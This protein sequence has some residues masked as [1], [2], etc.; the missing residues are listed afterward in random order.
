FNK[1]Y[2][3]VNPYSFLPNEVILRSM[4]ELFQKNGEAIP[5]IRKTQRPPNVLLIICK[6]FSEKVID[7]SRGGIEITPNFNQLK[8]EGFYFPNTYA[9]GDATEKGLVAILSGFPAQPKESI[10]QEPNKSR[11]LP[12]LTKDIQNKGYRT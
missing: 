12:F 5:V 1:A 4:K 6:N 3:K 8:K 9:A 11:N 7:Q 10:L 2:D